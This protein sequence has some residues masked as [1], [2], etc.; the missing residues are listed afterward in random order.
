MVD[1][2]F[3]EGRGPALVKHTF[4]ERYLPTLIAKVA[5]KYDHF[6][7]VDFFAGPWSSKCPD[8]SDTSFDI[9][10]RAMRGA[11][12]VW[13]RNGRDILMSAHFVEEDEEAYSKLTKHKEK[14]P[15]I[16]ITPYPGLAEDHAGNI[17]SGIPSGSFSFFNFDPKGVPDLA[18]FR[19]M[20]LRPSSEVL[21]TFMLKFAH[22]FAHTDAMPTLTSWLNE[23]GDDDK[24][25]SMLAQLTGQAK[26][27]AITEGARRTL[28]KLGNYN[29]APEITVDELEK[30]RTCYKLIFLTRHPKGIRVFRDAQIAALEAQAINRS[31]AKATARTTKTGMEDLFQ[32]VTPFEREERSAKEM[33]N[34]ETDARALTL[35]IVRSAGSEGLSWGELWPTVLDACVVTYSQLGKILSELRSSNQVS[36]PNWTNARIR[37][38]RDEFQIVLA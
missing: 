38:P 10:L 27:E 31:D 16:E 7:F 20:F 23:L 25:K 3:Y 2:Q 35:E 6:T 22:R 13:K 8:H 12:A 37:V 18:P 24:R 17:L 5:S 30:E 9:A 1:S 19:Q 33:R 26:E 32:A 36:M 29:F 11:K 28:A 21:L 4:I 34:G 15:D 14:Y